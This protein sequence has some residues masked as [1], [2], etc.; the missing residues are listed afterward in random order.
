MRQTLRGGVR[1]VSAGFKTP[2]DIIVVVVWTRSATR[3]RF[4]PPAGS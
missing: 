1:N 4:I 2:Q 3:K